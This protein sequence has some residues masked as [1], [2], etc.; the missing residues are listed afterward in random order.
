M[1]TRISSARSARRAKSDLGWVGR[2][3]AMIV[4]VC[5]LLSAC[6]RAPPAGADATGSETQP[7][8]GSK[9]TD[10]AAAGAPGSAAEGVSLTPAQVEKLGLV[11]QPAQPTAYSQH[12]S[13]YG[14][15]VSHDTIA[16]AVAELTT[17]RATE[18]QSR[19]ALK[20][21][22]QLS[23][24]PGA[25]SADVEEAAAQKAAVDAAATTLTTERLTSTLGMNP[26]WQNRDQDPTL[27]DL[28]RGKIKL[29][30]ATF[31]LGALSGGTPRSLRAA[32]LGVTQPDL[33]WKLNVVWDAPA[34][35]SIPG[36]SYFALLKGADVGEG[37]RLTVWAPIGEM[38]SGV[39]IPAAAVVM[40]EGR[41]W[42]YLEKKPG[43]FVRVEIDATK[44]TANGYFVSASISA[45]DQIVVT[46]A[47][48]LLAKELGAG[49][50][51][52]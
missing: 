8:S 6:H 43:A 29:L 42:C 21:A 27:Q 5:S 24:T 46:A 47:G 36:R 13:G 10:A 14:V 26:P 9:S 38:L 40:S 4:A 32:R 49:A 41:Y 33:G 30:R 1:P 17:A 51:P 48:Q 19:S 20:R 22:Q 31:P 7:A 25:V 50:E 11:T 39:L 3:A 52:D 34:D 18:L 28:A 16:Q 37:E 15:V 23:G 12:A 35:S 2:C 45:G 44:P